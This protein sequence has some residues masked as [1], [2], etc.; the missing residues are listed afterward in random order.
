MAPVMRL[1]FLGGCD[2][3]G[4]AS[5][6]RRGER[7]L[8][9]IVIAFAQSRVDPRERTPPPL[10]QL[11][12]RHRQ[13]ARQ[14]LGR[15]ALHQPQDHVALAR[16]APSLARCQRPLVVGCGQRARSKQ[17]LAMLALAVHSPNRHI[18]TGL[19]PVSWRGEGLGSRYLK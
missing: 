15:L 11:P 1:L 9:R 3:A 7:A 12:H 6:S 18:H 19:A 5:V 4:L 14:P 10:L 2:L 17:G 13:P 8:V 16:Q